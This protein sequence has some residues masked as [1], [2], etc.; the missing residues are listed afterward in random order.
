M[1]KKYKVSSKYQGYLSVKE[2]NT[3]IIRAFPY[4]GFE[5]RLSLTDL[6]NIA[7]A[8]GGRYILENR[9]L[10]EDPEIIELLQI[11][12]E[13]ED[14]FTKENI[15]DLLKNGTDEQLQDALEFG[16]LGTKELI[17]DAAVEMKLPNTHKRKII[18]DSV[19]VDINKVIDFSEDEE[20][21][22]T[23]VSQNT[24]STSRRSAPFV[25]SAQEPLIDDAPVA[26]RTR[27]INGKTVVY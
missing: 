5:M 1:E 7:Y 19:G 2:A 18:S 6:Q 4:F 21:N 12:L 8:P 20:E 24:A 11:H 13:P 14:R 10:F 27:V 25:P 16:S 15:Q 23:V 9:L 22:K 17:K 26:P 3:G